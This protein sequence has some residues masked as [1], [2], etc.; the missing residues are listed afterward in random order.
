MSQVTAELRGN[1]MCS[2]ALEV[3]YSLK[4]FSPWKVMSK[5]LSVV[6]SLATLC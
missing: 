5:L 1:Q 3:I 4:T 6:V 2:E